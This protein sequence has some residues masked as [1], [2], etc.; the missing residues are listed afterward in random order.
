MILSD[1]SQ[2]EIDFNYRLGF[3]TQDNQI[4]DMKVNILLKGS[5]INGI[6]SI[7][8]YCYQTSLI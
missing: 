1:N 8:Q 5:F 6:K 2:N 4:I 3:L 7:G